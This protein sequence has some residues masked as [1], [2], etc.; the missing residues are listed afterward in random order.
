MADGSLSLGRS[1]GRSVGRSAQRNLNGKAGGQLGKQQT[2][3]DGVETDGQET[4]QS[5]SRGRG[6]E[7]RKAEERRRE[8]R[9]RRGEES[10]K[11]RKGGT[12]RSGE[13]DSRGGSYRC[14]TSTLARSLALLLS[15][16][17][18]YIG[19][20]VL[21]ALFEPRGRYHPPPAA[22]AGRT[23]L[24]RHGER[25]RESNPQGQRDSLTRP[26]T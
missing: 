9:T 17:R 16:C 19:L 4:N 6:E 11:E 8:E 20:W 18:E 12:V 5:R 22:A 3:T 13:P 10:G 23:E 24:E 2:R 21:L 7:R 25:E 1:V 15:N 26:Q 14:S